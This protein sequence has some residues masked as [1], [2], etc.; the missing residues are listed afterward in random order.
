[1]GCSVQ[2]RLRFQWILADED[3]AWPDFTTQVELVAH[4]LVRLAWLSV[5]LV[6]D[7]PALYRYYRQRFGLS[8]DT[9]RRDKRKLRRIG[10]YIVAIS[11]L[12]LSTL[13]YLER[14]SVD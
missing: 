3:P 9:F 12:D 4:R 2:R 10:M 11:W 6:A 14:T 8:I 7:H 13:R 5:L 1:M